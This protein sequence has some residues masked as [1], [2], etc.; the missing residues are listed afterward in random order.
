[1]DK[2]NNEDF[3]YNVKEK[4]GKVVIE[5]I[6][7]KHESN[8]EEP[9]AEKE[10]PSVP[11][12]KVEDDSWYN[13]KEENGV[14]SIEK[15]SKKVK[16][17][18]EENEKVE[19]EPSAKTLE[20]QSN[21]YDA[22]ELV[23]E[24]TYVK[25]KKKTL[26]RWIP[27][28]G[29]LLVLI[30]FSFVFLTFTS[31]STKNGPKERTFMI[32]MVGSD[33]ESSGGI[34]S[35]DLKDLTSSSVDLD[36]TNVVLIVG[37]SKKWHNFVNEDEL[38]IYDLTS[39]GFE[40]RKT[41]G[42][43]NMGSSSTLSYFLDYSYE[44]Y[45][46]DKYDLLFWNHG[47]GAVGLE[48][49]ELSDDFVDI[50]ELDKSF[51]NSKFK[52]QKLE[53]VIFNNC[54]AGNIHFAKV[55]SKYADYMVASEEVMYVGQLIDRLDFLEDIDSKD[56]GYDIGLAYIENSDKSMNSA[57]KFTRSNMDST[58]SIIDLSKVSKLDSDLNKFFGSINISTNFKNV[59]YA[60]KKLFTYGE[61][62]DAS[63]DVVDLY[64][65]ID[66]LA[67]L[68]SDS[69]LATAVKDDLKSAVKYNSSFNNHSNGLSIYF[70]FNGSLD[71]IETH[72]YLFG[73]LWD[74]NYTK[75]INDFYD[76][77]TGTKKARRALSG[78]NVNYLKNKLSYKG[79]T[80][81]INL[82]DEEKEVYQYANVYIFSKNTTDESYKLLLRTDNVHLENNT[83]KYNHYGILNI[84]NT[85]N[86]SL[87]E[88]DN[89][90]ILYGALNDTDVISNVTISDNKVNLDR[91]TLDSKDK[92]SM[93]LM[94]V[95]END[96]VSFYNL[97]YIITENGKIKEDWKETVDRE[98]VEYNDDESTAKIDEK[99]L[100]GYYVLV[101]MFDI[102]NDVFYSEL[103]QIK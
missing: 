90:Y 70:P 5:K 39:S 54:L 42:N 18:D 32:Y 99:N 69:S 97:N 49:D 11:K 56:N 52:D 87:I 82:T 83:L 79:K 98:K 55:M 37:G 13:I 28:A 65:F 68:S 35:F 23:E 85:N 14:V 93:V 80:L 24:N 101:E 29:V 66:A 74:D 30:V 7:K 86:V 16:N 64:D 47:L 94:D 25:P 53:V 89:Q 45:P 62:V 102:N 4:D 1:M 3:Y 88:K 61:S 44:N 9:F 91:V 38:G 81:S 72:L 92:P 6:S 73:Q 51:N 84:N 59:G 58:L 96:K 60:R 36:S 12:P 95:E 75:F 103:T 21:D 22:P 33:L 50:T 78:S 41:L 17:D 34:A 100:K 71:V 15:K 48:A 77:A 8:E 27:V 57:N 20:E 46:A 19:E 26:T 67:P 31:K 2:D 63:Y 10:E 76:I 43:K 40:K